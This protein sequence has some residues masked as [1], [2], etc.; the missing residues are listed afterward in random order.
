[1]I[2]VGEGA[3]V[4]AANVAAVRVERMVNQPDVWGAHVDL[5]H[6]DPLTRPFA[7]PTADLS[8][9]AAV[10]CAEAIAAAVSAAAMFGNVP[11]AAGE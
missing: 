2:R 3:A 11:P 4:A 6:G 10:E 5:F 7:A 8:R 1:M 9:L